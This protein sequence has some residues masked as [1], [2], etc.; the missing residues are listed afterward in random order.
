MDL[1][2]SVIMLSFISIILLNVNE[3]SR[4]SGIIALDFSECFESCNHLNYYSHYFL[5]LSGPSV[6]FRVVLDFVTMF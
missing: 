4:S 1:V 6:Q 3:S 5:L 2:V